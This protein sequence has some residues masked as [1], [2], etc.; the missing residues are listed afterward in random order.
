MISTNREMSFMVLFHMRK[1][2]NA[3]KQARRVVQM[4]IFYPTARHLDF[5]AIQ[6]IT[7]TD[8]LREIK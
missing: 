6:C 8:E 7:L 5:E 1:L 3:V 4:S 2:D